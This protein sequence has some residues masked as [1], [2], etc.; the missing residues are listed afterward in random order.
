MAWADANE[1][2]ALSDGFL[3]TWPADHARTMTLAEYT[4]FSRS[5]ACVC[6]IGRASQRQGRVRRGWLA[7]SRKGHWA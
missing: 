2:Q 5:D 3:E 1:Q 6:W 7:T 4:N